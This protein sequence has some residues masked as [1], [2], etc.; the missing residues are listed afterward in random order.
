MMHV[1]MYVF[2][3]TSLSRIT[4][5]HILACLSHTYMRICTCIF[6]CVFMFI[7]NIYACEGCDSSYGET[8]PT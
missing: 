1:C 3:D 4:E 8:V 6:L 5:I 7:C 2:D